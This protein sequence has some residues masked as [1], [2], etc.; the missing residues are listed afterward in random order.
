MTR[1]QPLGLGDQLR[2]AEGV[3][4]YAGARVPG[5]GRIPINP[6]GPQPGAPAGSGPTDPIDALIGVPFDVGINRYLVRRIDMKWRCGPNEDVIDPEGAIGI[7]ER[8]TRQY[9]NHPRWMRLLETANTQLARVHEDGVFVL[10]WLRPD[11]RIAT[12]A[13]AA[14]ART[15]PP[16]PPVMPATRT[17]EEHTM[18]RRQALVLRNAART[19]VPFCEECARAANGAA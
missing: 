5:S 17:V 14:P 3:A 6:S 12:V 2:P 1:R 13:A 8:A 19:G 18:P 10:L 7:L 15:P 11:S 4:P 9:R 16:P